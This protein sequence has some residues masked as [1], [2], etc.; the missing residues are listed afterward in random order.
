MSLRTIESNLIL[1][2]RGGNDMGVT[3]MWQKRQHLLAIRVEMGMLSGPW[4]YSE[5]YLSKY[6]RALK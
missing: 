4:E 1:K 2:N 3:R 6:N 5:T